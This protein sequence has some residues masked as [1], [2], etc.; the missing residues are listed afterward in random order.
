MWKSIVLTMLFA[1]GMSQACSFLFS[2]VRFDTLS[3]GEV[4]AVQ[5]TQ[6]TNIMTMQPEWRYDTLGVYRLV[7]FRASLEA[8]LRDSALIFIGRVDTIAY[9]TTFA[10]TPLVVLGP[11]DDFPSRPFYARLIVDS[12]FK[13]SLPAKIF[14]VKARMP[15]HSCAFS[16]RT[17]RAFLNVSNKLE[18]TSDIK[19]P[20]TDPGPR[21]HY[22]GTAQWFD[23]RYIVSPK[24]PGLRLDITELYPDY[25]ATSVVP[26]RL[27]PLAPLRPDGMIY[28]PDGRVAPEGK[29]SFPLPVLR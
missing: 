8:D 2:Q 23:G 5:A 6:T 18:I 1:A 28:R 29:S 11:S 16:W 9:D 3:P 19:Q 22:I 12:L 24:F 7:D 14:W 25:P 13:G 27:P 10:P 20:T 17:G 15:S 21:G 4:R 26:R